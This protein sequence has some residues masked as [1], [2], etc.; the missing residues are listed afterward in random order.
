M[1]QVHAE[2]LP[3]HKAAVVEQL[4]AQGAKVAFVGDGVNDAPALIAADVGLA[5]PRGADLARATADIVLLD[6]RLETVLAARTLSIGTLRLI[7]HH[8]HLS[9]GLNTAIITGAAFGLLSPVW[10]ALL[11]NG[12]TLGVL[13]NSIIGINVRTHQVRTDPLESVSLS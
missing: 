5:M 1:D 2:C 6:E 3:E 8:F 12:M 4:R 11:H 9:T 7:R 10:S 13:A